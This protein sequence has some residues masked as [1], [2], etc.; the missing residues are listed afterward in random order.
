MP[1]DFFRPI[2]TTECT[3]VFWF[4][5]VFMSAIWGYN[6]IVY[7]KE[8]NE[9][10]KSYEEKVQ[11]VFVKYHH[12]AEAFLSE[13]ILSMLGWGSLYLILLNISKN[14]DKYDNFNIF[15]G[16]VAVICISGYGYKIAEKLGK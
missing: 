4:S 13:F 1:I 15:L 8:E 2:F 11:N 5:A 9:I 6:G 7:V 14:S 12:H 3:Y 16:T 10:N